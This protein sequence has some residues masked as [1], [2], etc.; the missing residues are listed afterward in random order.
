MNWNGYDNS[1]IVSAV[2]NKY[3]TVY[4]NIND[5]PFFFVNTLTDCDI[6]LTNGTIDNLKNTFG[7]LFVNQTANQTAN[8]TNIELINNLKQNFAVQSVDEYAKLLL[9]RIKKITTENT[10][11]Q[12]WTLN[13]F[14][15]SFTHWFNLGKTTGNNNDTKIN[16]IAGIPLINLLTSD[17][18]G[19]GQKSA[20]VDK[21]LGDANVQTLSLNIFELLKQQ[22]KDVQTFN[23]VDN[24]QTERKRKPGIVA[25]DEDDDKYNDF[26][27]T[28]GG[29]C[30]YKNKYLK[31]VSKCI[32]LKKLMKE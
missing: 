7:S 22:D 30:N 21:I 15:E 20:L 25:S 10:T 8:Q 3:G 24:T 1:N 14:I 11:I 9:T 31:Y 5:V 26:N 19:E 29:S 32:M 27:I 17:T 16:V 2:N 28:S 13:E 18:I 12:K 6:K 23:N 4:T